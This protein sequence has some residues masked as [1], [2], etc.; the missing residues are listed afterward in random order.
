MAGTTGRF[1]ELIQVQR[2]KGRHLNGVS[3]SE[4]R[5]SRLLARPPISPRAKGI[6]VSRRGS[7]GLIHPNVTRA[8]G[9]PRDRC[10]HSIK[11]KKPFH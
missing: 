5:R 6:R 9:G 2:G 7:H 8:A 4:R 3:A 1:G 10:D 11:V